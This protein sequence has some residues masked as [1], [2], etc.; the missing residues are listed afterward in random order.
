MTLQAN[1]WIYSIKHHHLPRD[2]ST[3]DG[4]FNGSNYDPA[5]P[6]SA[7]DSQLASNAQV[8]A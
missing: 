4:E 3:K 8:R 2:L 1:E 7:D 5:S 6:E